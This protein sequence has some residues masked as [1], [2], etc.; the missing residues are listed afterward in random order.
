MVR[1]H[2]IPL[3]LIFPAPEKWSKVRRGGKNSCKTSEKSHLSWS[4]AANFENWGI[5]N[6]GILTLKLDFLLGLRQ[7]LG[8]LFHQFGSLLAKV[9]FQ[10]GGI[11]LLFLQFSTIAYFL[12]SAEFGMFSLSFFIE[13]IAIF[14]I[15]ESEFSYINIGNLWRFRYLLVFE[16]CHCTLWNVSSLKWILFL[17]DFAVI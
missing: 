4:I 12:W 11:Y 1:I 7:D 9:E 3:F 8:F 17:E 14:F 13:H 2:S 15:V 5:K 16:H 6:Y 10:F